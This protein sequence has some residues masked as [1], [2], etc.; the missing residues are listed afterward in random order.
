MDILTVTHCHFSL[1]QYLKN[2]TKDQQSRNETRLQHL[3]MFSEPSKLIKNA[4]FCD[5]Q[6]LIRSWN[7]KQL[8]WEKLAKGEKE[9]WHIGDPT[10]AHE[11]ICLLSVFIHRYLKSERSHSFEKCWSSIKNL[12]AIKPLETTA[13]TLN[14]M[15]HMCYNIGNLTVN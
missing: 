12:T 5:S 8:R 3:A 15:S 14:H 7:L 1:A 2:K 11:Y 6:T 4:W 9:R 13:R 10:S